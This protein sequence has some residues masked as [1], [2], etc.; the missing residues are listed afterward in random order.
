MRQPLM[1]PQVIITIT[2]I[3][4]TLPRDL[5]PRDHLHITWHSHLI[6]CITV[7][8]SIFLVP[9]PLIMPLT[10]PILKDPILKNRLRRCSGWDPWQVQ[11]LVEIRHPL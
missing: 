11:P 2:L 1:I 10:M 6:K 7:I 3:N 4:I 9:L 8:I 5:L